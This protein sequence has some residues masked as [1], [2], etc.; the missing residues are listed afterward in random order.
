VGKPGLLDLQNVVHG[1]LK[2]LDGLERI[3]P[4]PLRVRIVCFF[5]LILFTQFI[6]HFTQEKTFCHF[7]YQIHFLNSTIYP[8]LYRIRYSIVSFL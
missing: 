3:F 2:M 4:K 8:L 6:V 5:E 7:F 1:F